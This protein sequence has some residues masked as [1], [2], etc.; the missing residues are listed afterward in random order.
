MKINKN[1]CN[2][3]Q[4]SDIKQCVIYLQTENNIIVI[5]IKVCVS[6]IQ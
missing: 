5:I 3:C 2:Q 4:F 1:K 6:F